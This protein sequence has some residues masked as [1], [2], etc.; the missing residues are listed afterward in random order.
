MKPKTRS[1]PLI[2]DESTFRV[3]IETLIRRSAGDD[4]PRQD[5]VEQL[6]VDLIRLPT[7]TLAELVELLAQARGITLDPDI[8]PKITRE[9][10]DP[11]L[12][13]P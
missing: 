5:L 13:E 12:R 2:Y 3:S 6:A 7:I 11:C 4:F 1:R 9:I 8:L 10:A